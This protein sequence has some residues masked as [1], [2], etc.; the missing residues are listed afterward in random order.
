MES[1]HLWGDSGT[2]QQERMPTGRRLRDQRR[3]R[4]P[5]RSKILACKEASTKLLPPSSPAPPGF[6]QEERAVQT[7]RRVFWAGARCLC[8]WFVF[9]SEK[10]AHK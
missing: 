5:G 7:S 2:P 9:P 10:H 1:T 3:K 8:P 4:L 6:H